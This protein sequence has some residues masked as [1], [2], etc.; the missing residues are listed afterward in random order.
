[1]KIIDIINELN[2]EN[3]SNYK[4]D[5]LKK[6]KDNE[7][8]KHVL[9]M[10]MDK[11]RF[12]YGVKK[13]PNYIPE[14]YNE[15]GRLTLEYTLA[16]LTS[17]FCTRVVTGNNAIEILTNLL[18]GLTKEDAIVLERV[19][20][21]DLK[22]GL[23]RTNVNKIFKDLIVKPVYQRCSVF[24]EDSIDKETKKVKKGTAKKIDW[25]NSVLNL[26]AD[27]TYRE[28]TVTPNTVDFCSRSG[29]D[30]SYPNIEEEYR[31]LTTGRYFGELTVELD[32]ALLNKIIPDIHKEDPEMAELITANFNN[33]IRTLPRAIGNGLINSDDVPYDNIVMD[34][35]EYV[36]EEEYYNAGNK[37][38]NTSKYF[39]RFKTME[40][41]INS[42]DLKHIRVIEYVI[43]KS[44]KEALAQVSEWM[45][46]GLE[47][48]ILKDTNM[49]FRDGTHPSQL[50]IKLIIDLDLRVT[51]FTEG[52]K[53]TKREKTFGAMTFSNDE[54][55]I[56]G[57]T[58][59][60]SDKMLEE[61]NNNR[62]KYIGQITTIICNDITKGRGNNFWALSHP[63]WDSFRTDKT[64]TD[65]L[66][67]VLDKK[68]SAMG[69]K[70]VL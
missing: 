27:G 11:V 18:S 42:K 40:E 65:T 47:G 41:D 10:T 17:S 13:I 69:L 44:K 12:T 60:F 64:T 53:G 38:K 70:Q 55:T 51:G 37:I 59:G 14:S 23:G 34:V 46:K 61:I 33:G 25:N 3:G 49:V 28:V 68:D 48:G 35:W 8:F 29:E 6:H 52:T 62:E 54:G 1:M 50:K 63:R 57:Q 7:L 66:E 31:Q 22:V 36:A 19:I 4:L 45:N 9:E 67:E 2:L 26:K 16:V 5:I 21:R 39:D 20:D 30:Y 32:E 56:K 24:T 43:V 15:F 58:S